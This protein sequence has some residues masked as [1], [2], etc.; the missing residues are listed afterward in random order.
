M[1]EDVSEQALRQVA[2]GKLD[3]EVPRM[4]EPVLN[5]RCWRLVREQLWVATGR[6][7]RHRRLP[8]LEAMW[9]PSESRVELDP[10]NV[11]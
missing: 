8:K 7:S 6:T 9:E 11:G 10:T 2:F 3:D 4:A 5:S 1:P